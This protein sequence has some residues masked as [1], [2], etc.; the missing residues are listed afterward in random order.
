MEYGKKRLNTRLV[1]KKDFC[2]ANHFWREY[3]YQQTIPLSKREGTEYLFHPPKNL[4]YNE[5]PAICT[6]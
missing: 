2:K 4:I 1:R 5:S 6:F 3:C